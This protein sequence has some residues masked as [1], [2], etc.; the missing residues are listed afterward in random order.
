[1]EV[2]SLVSI[3]TVNIGDELASRAGHFSSKEKDK[4]AI[5]VDKF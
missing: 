2:N 3:P 4:V 5:N 1:V